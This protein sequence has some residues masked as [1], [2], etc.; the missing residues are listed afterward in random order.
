MKRCS[1]SRGVD[2]EKRQ[3]KLSVCDDDIYIVEKISEICTRFFENE[4]VGCD[5][6]RTS[7]GEE[8][9]KQSQKGDLLIIDIDM[10]EMNGFEVVEQLQLLKKVENVVFV[11][12]LS[13]LVY[14]CFSYMPFGFVRKEIL[15]EEL[16][17][18]L[19]RYISKYMKENKVYRLKINGIEQEIKDSDIVYLE[20]RGHEV[21]I[22]LNT[23]KVQLRESLRHMEQLLG[24]GNFIRIHHGYLVNA[25]YI[26]MIGKN[27][28][29]LKI[30]ESLPMSRH[31]REKVKK[32]YAQYLRMRS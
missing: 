9:I 12:N 7:S 28:C 15:E 6:Y 16:L 3:I 25:E 8:L 1:I 23:E 22:Q 26:K 30:N 32:Q 11:T 14:E 13:Q 21:F 29:D 31:R 2:M 4:N 20:S 17:V 27:M 10:P 19:Q 5:I 24:D 18:V